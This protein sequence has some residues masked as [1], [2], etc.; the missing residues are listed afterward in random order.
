MRNVVNAG[1]LVALAAFPMLTACSGSDSVDSNSVTE[2]VRGRRATACMQPDLIVSSVTLDVASPNAGDGVTFTA[3]VTNNGGA[4]TPAGTV[5]GVG[6]SVD[7]TLVAWSDTDTASLAPGASVKLTANSGPSGSRKYAAVAGAHTVTA[8]VNDVNRFSECSTANNFGYANFTVGTASAPSTPSNPSTPAPAGPGMFY[9]INGHWG[10]NTYSA[11]PIAT[12]KGDLADL[13]VGVIRT[14]I[15]NVDNAKMIVTNAAAV[16]PVKVIPIYL[17]SLT[18]STEQSSY[19]AAYSLAAS[20]TTVLQG[21]V[22]YYEIGNEYD[23]P[24]YLSG[25]GNVPS[26]YDNTCF[27]KYRGLMRGITDGIR[28]VDKS[29]PIIGGAI[30]GWLHYAWTDMLWNGTQ[31]DGSSGHPQVRWDA[32]VCHWYSDMGSITNACGGSGCYNVLDILKSHY[33]KPIY[34]TEFG[35]RPYA[36]ASES[37][38]ADYMTNTM[39][40]MMLNNAD[41]Y[42]IAGI[43]WYQLYSDAEGS[44]G[45]ID[46]DGKTKTAKYNALKNFI[47]AHPR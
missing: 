8:Y 19:D 33:G 3:T 32:T 45:V 39:L 11:L 44:Y 5:I 28:S 42:G 21:K 4:A 25:D 38:M 9:G 26:Q 29:T 27:Q 31:P 24:C 47:A 23:A 18:G 12:Q 17:F 14:D 15:Y 41:K 46:G 10:R 37:A 7:N 16:A 2:D 34:L 20:M 35:V 43:D 40:P 6:F 36:F 22:P 13:G 30:A 1:V